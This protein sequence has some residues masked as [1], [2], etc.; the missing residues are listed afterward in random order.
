MSTPCV[1]LG[2]S[3]SSIKYLFLLIKKKKNIMI[4]VVPS[5]IF[6]LFQ[7]K[8]KT[9]TL[10]TTIKE[11][12]PKINQNSQENFGKKEKSLISIGICFLSLL[13]IFSFTFLMI[14]VHDL[15]YVNE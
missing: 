13:L 6:A 9:L 11:K 12:R 15:A 1:L 4:M 8:K 3:L 7:A 14:L 2:T 5:L 10:P